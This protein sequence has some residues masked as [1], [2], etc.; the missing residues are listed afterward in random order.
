[1]I[2]ITHVI[3][4]SCIKSEP[5]KQIANL[6][7][8]ISNQSQMWY[9]GSCKNFFHRVVPVLQIFK[10]T[11]ICD[12][13]NHQNTLKNQSSAYHDK[14]TAF[15]KKITFH[16]YIEELIQNISN[17]IQ[18][19]CQPFIELHHQSKQ[20]PSAVCFEAWNFIYNI[21]DYLLWWSFYLPSVILF[22]SSVKLIETII[23]IYTL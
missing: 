2:C 7:T 22:C 4:I 3:F 17:N 19:D 23:S 20:H 18:Y 9:S 6:L 8:F 11:V 5:Q 16:V 21:I 14:I 13:I 10:T 15:E 1:M 12:I